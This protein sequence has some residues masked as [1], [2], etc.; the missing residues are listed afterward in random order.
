MVNLKQIAQSGGSA[1]HTI[2]YDGSNWANFSY[3][4]FTYSPD[5][6]QCFFDSIATTF[7]LTGALTIN[8][9]S[10]NSS[11]NG[12]NITISAQDSS[13]GNGGICAI[14]GGNSSFDG[15]VGGHVGLY[16]GDATG[17]IDA[18]GGNIYLVPG[19]KA[20]DGYVGEVI[21]SNVAANAGVNL[22]PIVHNTGSV[23]T[24]AKRWSHIYCN[25][26]TS[27][28]VCFTDEKC[29]I[30]NSEFKKND[31]LVFRIYEQEIKE[32]IK[33]NK[34]VPIHAKCSV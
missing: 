11:T 34:T 16:G 14:S 24:V 19:D 22:V 9:S 31:D 13:A 18:N 28:D 8:M 33:I 12:Y 15:G 20:Q 29:I 1:G 10:I 17:S 32:G 2:T 27:N 23:G 5:D 7:K 4:K 30:C 26:I 25:Q 6:L 21:I 3:V